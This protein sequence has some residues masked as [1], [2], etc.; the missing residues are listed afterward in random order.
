MVNYFLFSTISYLFLFDKSTLRHPKFIKNQIWGEICQTVTAM[1]TM[2]FF[3]ALCFLLEVRGYSR[4][5]DPGAD[6]SASAWW[7]QMA[8]PLLFILFTDWG[9]YWIHR[10]LHH[11]LLYKYLHKPHH[12]WIMPSPYACYAFHPLDGFA[13]SLPYHIYPFLFPLHKFVYLGLFMFVN[14]WTISIHDELFIANDGLINGAACH[15]AHHL[16]FK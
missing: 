4:L 3:T 14:I 9:I 1:P 5:Y 7:Y 12:R 13:Q 6:G 2:A 16:Y 15:T 11:P 8:S 10:A